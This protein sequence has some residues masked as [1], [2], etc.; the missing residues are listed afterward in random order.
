MTYLNYRSRRGIG[1]A[2]AFLGTSQEGEDEPR[3]RRKED[4]QQT[5]KRKPRANAIYKS[6]GGYMH[7]CNMM[8]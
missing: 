8:T 7:V 4:N 3:R 2:C 1:L 5:N 6:Q